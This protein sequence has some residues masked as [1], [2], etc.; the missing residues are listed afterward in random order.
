M[1]FVRSTLH[2]HCTF[3]DGAS[4]PQEMAEAA[5]K[6]G[7]TDIGF[8]SHTRPAFEPDFGVADEAAYVAAIHALR[9]RYAGRLRV[10][11]GMELDYYALPQRRAALDY[12][13]GSLHFL[14][15]PR[16]SRYFSVDGS[17]RELA[18]GIDALYGGDGLAAAR[19]YYRTLTRMARTL[20]PDVIGH[21]DIIVKMNQGNRFFDEQSPAYR[22]A[23][24]TA[25][26]EAAAGGAVFEINTRGVYRGHRDAPYPARFLLQ[27]LRELRAP[28][29][30]AADCHD[31]RQLLAG[32]DDAAALLADIGFREIVFWQDG[33]FRTAALPS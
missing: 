7:F 24:L 10:W 1:S 3:C 4:T 28:V 23:A 15:E 29:M 20:R 5:L 6:A 26:E 33:R 25:L 22:D 14:H 16:D 18:Q 9:A 11:C 27:R 17:A 30:L 8:S 12:C 31:A 32:L 13:I 21:F 2:N 19:A